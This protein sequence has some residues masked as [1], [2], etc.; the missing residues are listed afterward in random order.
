MYGVFFDF[1]K[2]FDTTLQYCS[3][4]P[5]EPDV[6]GINDRSIKNIVTKPGNAS[7]KPP[8][9]FSHTFIEDPCIR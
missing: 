1:G 4:F 6:A 2:N 7:Q 8:D 9:S 3:D 5:L